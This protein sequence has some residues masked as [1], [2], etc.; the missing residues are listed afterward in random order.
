MRGLSNYVPNQLVNEV[1][2]GFNYDYRW[3]QA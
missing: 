3:Y 1:K 2:Y